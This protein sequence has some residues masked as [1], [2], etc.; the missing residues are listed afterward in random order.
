MSWVARIGLAL[1][2]PRWALAVAGDRRHPGRAG[3]D[4]IALI[5]VVVLATQLRGLVAA[6]WLGAELGLGVGARGVLRL[7][8]Q[9]LTVDLGF[10]VVA[11][12]VVFA[13]AGARRD[14]GRAFDL[15]CVAAVPLLVVQLVA[16]AVVHAAGLAVGPAV[17]WAIA[18]VS[19]GWAGVIVALAVRPARA[20][21]TAATRPVEVPA[22]VA[23]PA[24][25]TGWVV[26]ALA[27]LGLAAQVRTIVADLDAMRPVTDGGPAPTFVLREVG[28]GQPHALA[29]ARGQVVV[30]E[31]WATWCKPC[32]AA[33][34]ALEALSQRP[35]VVV[36]AIN[37]DDPAAA[38][39][40][41]DRAGYRMRLLADDGVVSERYN[42]AT[43][44]HSVVIGRDG[45]VRHVARGSSAG[46]AAQVDAAIAAP[47]AAPAAP[48]TPT[49]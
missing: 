46:L 1:A 40:L 43:I 30:L 41:F 38:R 23:R 28:S 33:L 20:A 32:I 11:A 37:L 49:P 3:S 17:A 24:R 5:A 48:G 14:L 7:L 13:A 18:G 29:A 44:P 36:Y 45:V 25:R 8:T 47:G 16:L 35:G 26:V 34:P 6:G 27:V 39:A 4:L 10:L 12:L 31:F 21:V 22:E 15:A 9:A 2:R 42:V 19:W